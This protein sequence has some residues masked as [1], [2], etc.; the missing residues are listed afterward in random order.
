MQTSIAPRIANRSRTKVL[1]A[2]FIANPILQRAQRFLY[3][4]NPIDIVILAQKWADFWRLK[5][6]QSTYMYIAPCM[7]HKPLWSAQAWITQFNLQRT[8]CLPLPRKRSSD[9]ASTDWGGEH[10]ISAYYSFIDPER[11]KGWVDLQRTVYPHKWSP[12][13]WRSSVGQWKFASQDR[14]RDLP[15]TKNKDTKIY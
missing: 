7:V 2:N 6:K 5:V 11:M 8:P 1:Y 12:I 14:E 9:G 4:T 10:L 3:C 15:Q 13:S